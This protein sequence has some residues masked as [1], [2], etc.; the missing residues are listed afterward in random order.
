MSRGRGYS[1]RAW[2]PRQQQRHEFQRRISRRWQRR[3]C[4]RRRELSAVYATV[5]VTALAFPNNSVSL[6]FLPGLYF[7][8]LWGV[9]E[10]VV[11][12]VMGGLRGWA[13]FERYAHL[14]EAAFGTYYVC[15]A[16]R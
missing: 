10:M 8:I 4:S 1:T 3:R 7:S 5:V 11:I 9:G 2:W 13:L 16:S 14:G 15:M 6:I 12:D